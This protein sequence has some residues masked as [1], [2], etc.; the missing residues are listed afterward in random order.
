MKTR[1]LRY[2]LMSL[3]LLLVIGMAL[4]LGS[5]SFEAF[6]PFGGMEEPLGSL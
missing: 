6:C 3:V 2:G 1:Y 4:G 5:R